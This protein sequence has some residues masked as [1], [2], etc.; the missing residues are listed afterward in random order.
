MYDCKSYAG[1]LL[2][3]ERI[4]IFTKAI[5]ASTGKGDTVADL[6]CGLGTY[7]MAAAR[8]GARKVFA[9]EKGE[10]FPLLERIVRRNSLSDIVIPVKESIEKWIPPEKIDLVI[11]EDFPKGG[12]CSRTL[13]IIKMSKE[14]FPGARF[15]PRAIS[16]KAAPVKLPSNSGAGEKLKASYLIADFDFTVLVDYLTDNIYSVDLE[17]DSLRGDPQ[18]MWTFNFDVPLPS[19]SSEM[20]WQMD[21]G[22]ECDGIVFWFELDLGAGIVLSNSPGTCITVWGQT[23]CPFS[24]CCTASDAFELTTELSFQQNGDIWNWSASWLDNKENHSTAFS[25]PLDK[26][27]F[28]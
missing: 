26:N 9:V 17:P 22:A 12:I 13:N 18:K 25:E 8:A 14:A 10:I 6:G 27:K 4:E 16:F 11:F 2:D 20:S 23:L 7:A 3:R 24:R 21:A 5:E 15:L 19:F 28:F 1:L